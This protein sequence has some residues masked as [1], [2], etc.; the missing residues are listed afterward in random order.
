[1]QASRQAAA[2]ARARA[3]AAWHTPRSA[4][5]WPPPAHHPASACCCCLAPPPQRA[6]PLEPAF[7][8]TACGSL[9]PLV[10]IKGGWAAREGSQP[11]LPGV[12]ALH[13]PLRPTRCRGGLSRGGE[14]TGSPAAAPPRSAVQ[15][16]VAPCCLRLHVAS[17]YCRPWPCAAPLRC[18]AGFDSFV[19]G[20]GRCAWRLWGALPA[21]AGEG[22]EVDQS[23]LV[24]W[25]AGA[26]GSG[27]AVGA[28]VAR[29]G[30]ACLV[31]WLEARRRLAACSSAGAGAAATG[32]SGHVPCKRRAA[33]SALFA[34]LACCAV[35]LSRLGLGSVRLDRP[36]FP[37]SH[38]P[39]GY[40]PAPCRGRL[41]PAGP[42]AQL[43]PAVGG[44]GWRA[45]R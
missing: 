23:L 31:G 9:A 16:P 5:S 26:A 35:R 2:W 37:H 34:S 32:S 44:G 27:T 7:V 43:L 25:L 15:L 12:P 39:R 41:L 1:M 6:C 13:T 30:G 14:P 21:A 22:P 11:P 29:P 45:Q 28:L 18:G 42:A 8:W 10:S 19:G 24:R 20:R 3:G 40:R 38:T 33:A 4:P 17:N 36:P